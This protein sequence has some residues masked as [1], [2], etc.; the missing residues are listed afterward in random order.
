MAR[1][2]AGFPS[3]A[4]D[5]AIER[6]SLDQVLIQHPLATY[7]VT[8]KGDSMRDAGID[9]GDRLL[10]D[11]AIRPAQHRHIVVA[12]IDGELTLKRLFKRG[13]VVKLE[14]ANPTYPDIRIEAFSELVIWGVATTCIKRL[15]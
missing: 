14:A 11:R 3:P 4:A 6:I 9:D 15:S 1:L 2:P 10:V 5:H 13:G 7:V 8:V 12:M